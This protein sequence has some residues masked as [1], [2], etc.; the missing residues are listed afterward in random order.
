MILYKTKENNYQLFDN[1][2]ICVG[3]GWVSTFSTFSTLVEL[4]ERC[5]SEELFFR[6]LPMHRSYDS[7]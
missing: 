1:D 2:K 5:D 7:I 6:E 3:I 4:V